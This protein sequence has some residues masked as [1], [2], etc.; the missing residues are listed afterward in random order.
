MG[1]KHFYLGNA[2]KNMLATE[3]LENNYDFDVNT[4]VYDESIKNDSR[5]AIAREIKEKST[6]LDI[7]CASGILGYLLFKHKK[8]TVDGIEYDKTASIIARNKNVYRDVYNFSI[9]DIESKKYK[10]F[11]SL[12]RKYD[13]VIFA[14]VL[15]HLVDPWSAIVN[16]ANLLKSDGKII[17]SLPNISNIDVIKALVNGEF[18]Y[19]KYGILDQTHLRFFT[20]N[21]VKDMLDNIADVYKCY[22]SSKLIDEIVIK[23]EY[24]DDELYRF[25]NLKEYMPLQYIYIL[26]KVNRREDMKSNIKNNQSNKFDKFLS[27]YNNLKESNLKYVNDISELNRELNEKND[28][29]DA[30]VNSKRWKLINKIMRIFGK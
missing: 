24:I 17:I 27:E 29:L 19:N 9:S 23:P 5:I 26:E 15:E 14:D 7:G 11:V 22:F 28:E 10:E 2:E 4:Y 25:V 21:S 12:K 16:S 3:N 18:N 8:C 6:A 1:N 13:Y 20:P 30:I